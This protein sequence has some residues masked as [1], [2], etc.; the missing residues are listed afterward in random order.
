MSSALVRQRIRTIRKEKGLR[1]EDVARGIGISRPYFTQLEGGKR[2]LSVEHVIKIAQILK[3]SV[4][5]LFG[6]SVHHVA[7]EAHGAARHLKPI[8][9][10]ALKQK[11]RPLLGAQTEDAVTYLGL[12]FEASEDVKQAL[13]KT[14]RAS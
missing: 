8:N 12:W 4:S 5:E 9:M 13:M 3:V 14:A 10:P 7:P 1:A 11:L 6:E 2:R